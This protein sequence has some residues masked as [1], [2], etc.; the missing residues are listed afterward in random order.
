MR[1]ANRILA[2]VVALALFAGAV[3]VVAE[4]V[5]AVFGDRPWAIPYRQWY[6]DG[7]TTAWDST[8]VR[9]VSAGLVAVGLVL[10]VSQLAPR[11]PER[12]RVAHRN[13]GARADVGRRSVEQSVQRAVMPLDGVAG[14]DVRGQRRS[15]R[16]RVQSSRRVPGDLEHK[17]REAAAGRLAELG[18]AERLRLDVSVS[19]REPG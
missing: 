1:V 10:I 6:G 2:A 14:A 11:R 3:L 18:L 17:V 16:V 12:L 4:V 7:A 5:A 15:V 19:P 8:L 13:D 9:L